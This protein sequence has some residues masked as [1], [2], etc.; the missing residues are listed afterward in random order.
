MWPEYITLYF[1]RK[2]CP[3]VK[4]VGLRL[5]CNNTQTSLDLVRSRLHR[6]DLVKLRNY[7]IYIWFLKYILITNFL[8]VYQITLHILC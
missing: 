1:L 4:P 6:L 5:Q 3:V 8:I 7:Q 2:G